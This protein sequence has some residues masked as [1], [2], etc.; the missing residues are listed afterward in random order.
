MGMFFNSWKD[1]DA[2]YYY[3]TVSEVGSSNY[4]R[5]YDDGYEAGKKQLVIDMT[6]DIMRDS[7]QDL[8]SI[9]KRKNLS[10]RTL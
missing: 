9:F 1:D 8:I 10:K 7:R 4:S 2:E 3:G 6:K 5:G